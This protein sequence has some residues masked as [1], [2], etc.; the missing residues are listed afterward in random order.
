MRHRWPTGLVTAAFAAAGIVSAAWAATLQGIT[1]GKSTRA[2]MHQRFGK[3]VTGM[4][5]AIETFE[6]KSTGLAK[7]T[8]YYDAKNVVNKASLVP[9]E[10]LTLDL[11]TLLFDLKAMPRTT[12]GHPYH[13]ATREG[14]TTHFDTDGV[15]FYVAGQA[16]REVWL[17][18]PG[19]TPTPT[20]APPRP[21]TPAAPTPTQPPAVPAKATR[22][23]SMVGNL[24]VAKAPPQ[25]PPKPVA[26]PSKPTPAAVPLAPQLPEALVGVRGAQGNAQASFHGITIGRSTQR[27]VQAMLGAPR[28]VSRYAANAFACEHDG[29]PLGLRAVVVRYRAD[30]VVDQ[31]DVR[32]LQAQ[33]KAAMA[34]ALG[35]GAPTGTLAF[36]GAVTTVYAQRG[37]ELTGM[38]NA[39]SSLRL[40]PVAPAGALQPTPA[41]L[42]VMPPAQP[43]AKPAVATPQAPPTPTAPVAAPPPAPTRAAPPPVTLGP[44]GVKVV[45]VW[46]QAG[47][48]VGAQAI[49]QAAGQEG[50]M[51][52]GDVAANGYHGKQ[53]VVRVRLR[54]YDGR[55]VRAAAGTPAQYVDKRRRFAVTV[56]TAVTDAQAR[57]TSYRVFVPFRYLGLV[58]GRK[59]RLIIVYTAMCGMQADTVEAPCTFMVP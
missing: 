10:E 40:A 5:S 53:L 46:Y 33:P 2:E 34:A 4:G 11:A 29:A 21:T 24:P 26:L 27:D 20:V 38:G 39:I 37:V 41:A 56:P 52:Y 45:R 49:G 12:Q 35:L 23:P 17:I 55:A 42:P 54:G 30:G 36:G 15:L 50:L 22:P 25:A 51:V 19:A 43:P 6:A 31:I 48:Q 59:Q 18:V 16:V 14:A 13:A 32:M 47:K 57:W 28:Y 3:P 7:V 1:P 44:L 58:R 8:L 9:A